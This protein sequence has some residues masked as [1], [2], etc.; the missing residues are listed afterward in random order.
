MKIQIISLAAAV[1]LVGPALSGRLHAGDG[2]GARRS[3]AAAPSGGPLKIKARFVRELAAGGDKAGQPG[4]KIPVDKLSFIVAAEG[5]E[6]RCE[7]GARAKGADVLRGMKIATPLVIHGTL[8]SRRNVLIVDAVAQGWG[9][10]QME[11]G[12]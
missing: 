5:G 7:A 2:A 3:G 4:G 9:I 11:G 8:D 6:M 12:S 1:M 10:E